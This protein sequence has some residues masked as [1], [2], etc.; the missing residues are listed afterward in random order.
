ME[1]LN[2]A[3]PKNRIND[4]AP[5]PHPVSSIG[6]QGKEKEDRGWWWRSVHKEGDCLSPESSI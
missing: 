6:G 4:H 1:L 5:F 2:C 3:E